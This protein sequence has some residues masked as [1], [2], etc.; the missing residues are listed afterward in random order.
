M[1]R[2][3]KLKQ[4]RKKKYYLDKIKNSPIGKL[5]DYQILSQALDIPEVQKIFDLM[6]NFNQELSLK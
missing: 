1:G 5:A 4:E 2:Q 3:A 6:A